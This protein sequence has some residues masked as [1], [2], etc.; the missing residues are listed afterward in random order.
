MLA[1]FLA[2]TVAFT[3]PLS[4]MGP[5]VT[6]LRSPPQ[7]IRME[8]PLGYQTEST[9]AQELCTTLQ[10]S[11]EIMLLRAAVGRCAEEKDM[12]SQRTLL[13]Q[14]EKVQNRVNKRLKSLQA[15]QKELTD[16]MRSVDGVMRQSKAPLGSDFETSLTEL[17]R[18][19]K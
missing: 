12:E 3:A 16:L 1:A 18:T 14:C 13:L 19:L 9:G 10:L 6:V 8:T 5:A 4:V 17:K 2:A 11:D 15:Q 7:A